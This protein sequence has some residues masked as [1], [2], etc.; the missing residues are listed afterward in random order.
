[1]ASGRGSVGAAWRA[2]VLGALVALGGCAGGGA[3]D[4]EPE[5]AAAAEEPTG[6]ATRGASGRG[7]GSDAEGSDAEHSDAEGSDTEGSDTEGSDAEDDGERGGEM[8]RRERGGEPGDQGGGEPGDDEVGDGADDGED[9]GDERPELGAALRWEIEERRL[10][11]PSHPGTPA[12]A[13]HAIVARPDAPPV[14]AVVFLHGWSG[15]ARVLAL[16]GRVACVPGGPPRDG[17][18]LVEAHE[19]AGVAAVFV[20]PQLAWRARDGRAGR[21]VREGFAAE[22]LASL[23]IPARLPLTLVAHSAGFETALAWLRRGGLGD[24]VR[25]VVLMDALYAG[26]ETF[27]AWVE[28]APER[29]LVSFYTGR[30]STARQNARLE[31]LASRRGVRVSGSLDEDAPVRVLRSRVAHGDVPA[32]HLAETLLRLHDQSAGAA[33]SVA[34]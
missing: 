4:G 13:P 31:R 16:P 19:A 33:E 7:E 20:L 18:G 27:L 9:R 5:G 24:R 17:W 23:A 22:T 12:G 14:G 21:Y 1:M 34:P 28:A 11:R 29:R 25:H 26:T 10:E 3:A 30:G 32:E 15:C 8:G 6:E 2:G